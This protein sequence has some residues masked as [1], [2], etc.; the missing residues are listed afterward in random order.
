ME[1]PSMDNHAVQDMIK[2]IVET[3]EFEPL[4]NYLSDDVVFKVTIPPGTPISGEFRGKQAVI[5]YFTS[6]GDIATFRQERPLEF[7]IRGERIVVLGDDSF[8]I[9]K[10]GGTARSEYALVFD[11]RDGLITRF[12]II[13]DLS[14]FVDAYRT[15]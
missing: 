3:S 1:H 9:K 6:I 10:S 7:F 8:T 11:I 5:D 2:E 14:A 15:S 4:F 13:Q 12:L